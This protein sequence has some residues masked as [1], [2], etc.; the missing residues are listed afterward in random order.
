MRRNIQWKVTFPISYRS[1]ERLVLVL[2]RCYCLVFSILRVL[3]WK[4]ASSSKE[5]AYW[6]ISLAVPAP[7]A[8]WNSSPQMRSSHSRYPSTLCWLLAPLFHFLAVF[9]VLCLFFLLNPCVF[10]LPVW[11]FNFARTKISCCPLAASGCCLDMLM[12]LDEL[13]VTSLTLHVLYVP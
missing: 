11:V 7:P 12:S 1:S 9:S 2:T 8:R 10:F 4:M 3:P 5:K 6:T 13:S